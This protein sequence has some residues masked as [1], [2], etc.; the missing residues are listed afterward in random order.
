MHIQ[1]YFVESYEKTLKDIKKCAIGR[2]L[3]FVTL[4]LFAL[5]GKGWAEDNKKPS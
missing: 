5:K 2:H 4:T 1:F 3:L